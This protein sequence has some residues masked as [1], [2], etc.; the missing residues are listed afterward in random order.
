M[1]GFWGGLYKLC[2]VHCEHAAPWLFVSAA[3]EA[4]TGICMFHGQQLIS[5]SA[6][7]FSRLWGCQLLCDSC[8]FSFS[9]S[10]DEY[11]MQPKNTEKK[12]MCLS[13]WWNQANSAIGL[14]IGPL[15]WKQNPAFLRPGFNDLYSFLCINL[16]DREVWAIALEILTH[17]FESISGHVC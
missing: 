3:A 4:Q 15:E 2:I 14:D 17:S 6:L 10:L 13:I 7:T 5:G 8:I 16:N 11:K 9:L 1:W 12:R